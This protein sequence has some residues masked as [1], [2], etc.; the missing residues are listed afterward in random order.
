M[1]FTALIEQGVSLHF[2]TIYRNCVTSSQINLRD[3]SQYSVQTYQSTGNIAND[4]KC[5]QNRHNLDRIELQA[6]QADNC[7]NKISTAS[8]HKPHQIIATD[9]FDLAKYESDRKFLGRIANQ[10][11]NLTLYEAERFSQLCKELGGTVV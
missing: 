8:I 2:N 3:L 11:G 10:R 7:S 4:K 9:L 1:S 5:Y 6:Y